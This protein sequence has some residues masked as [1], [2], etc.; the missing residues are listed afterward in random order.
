MA[1]TCEKFYAEKPFGSGLSVVAEDR[2]GLFTIE[3][4]DSPFGS[5]GDRI[6]F[7]LR[8]DRVVLPDPGI[9]VIR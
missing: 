9:I 6:D 4:E 8:D 1:D 7:E 2:G 3:I 5:P